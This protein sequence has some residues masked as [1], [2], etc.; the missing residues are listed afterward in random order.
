MY[1]KVME[2]HCNKKFNIIECKNVIN[3]LKNNKSKV[4]RK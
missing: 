2:N 3:L 1:D 4:F